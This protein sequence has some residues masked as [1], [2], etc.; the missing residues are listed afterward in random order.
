MPGD[1]ISCRLFFYL[2]AARAPERY[3]SRVVVGS[4]SI[5]LEE[6][7]IY[8]ELAEMSRGSTMRQKFPRKMRLAKNAIMSL[9]PR[10]PKGRE[11][12]YRKC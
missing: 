3:I 10:S 8:L 6:S 1:D 4:A 11:K 12:F 7:T 9:F 2:L 5:L